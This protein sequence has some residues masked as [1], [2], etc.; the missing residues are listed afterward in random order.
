M[1]TKKAS[2]PWQSPALHFRVFV[3]RIERIWSLG[4]IINAHRSE[5]P[6]L[7]YEP[8]CQGLETVA[9]MTA[10]SPPIVWWRPAALTAHFGSDGT[11]A[12]RF[13]LCLPSTTRRPL[14]KGSRT[15]RLLSLELEVELCEE[16]GTAAGEPESSEANI[17]ALLASI[18]LAGAC[19]G[20]LLT[21]RQWIPGRCTDTA[22]D[23]G[24]ADGGEDVAAP[25]PP[26]RS[27]DS[28]DGDAAKALLEGVGGAGGLGGLGALGG[29]GSL[30]TQAMRRPTPP[31]PTPDPAIE[32]NGVPSE[33]VSEAGVLAA[34]AALGDR[35]ERHLERH[36]A[37]VDARLERLEAKLDTAIAARP[38]AEVQAALEGGA[39]RQ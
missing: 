18:Q 6:T 10:L 20:G 21:R 33:V 30:L 38:V 12:R 11:P 26:L 8:G 32:A 2:R 22:R 35:L 25:P 24:R 14:P 4:P 19:Q 27:G 1:L 5:I 13:P 34:V 39:C 28:G 37:A 9:W 31:A 7:K 15:L 36:M 17:G 29:L 23:P 16:A 3:D